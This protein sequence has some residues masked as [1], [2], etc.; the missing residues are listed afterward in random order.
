[1]SDIPDA[2]ILRITPPYRDGGSFR[3]SVKCPHCLEI[4]Y[5]GLGREKDLWGHRTADCGAD[6]G[7]YVKE[8]TDDAT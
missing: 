6:A 1:M 8:P 5:H 4:H 3:V 2:K 7:Y